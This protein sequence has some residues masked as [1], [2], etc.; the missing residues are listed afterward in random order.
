MNIELI[1]QLASLIL[2]VASGPIVIGLLSLK[3]GNL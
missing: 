2:I 3:Q 1:T